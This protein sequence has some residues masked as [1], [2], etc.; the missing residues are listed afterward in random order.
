MSDEAQGS[1]AVPRST[2]ILPVS[3]TG[4]PP[5]V[6][7]PGQQGRD[8]PATHGQDARDT[9]GRDARAT[10]ERGRDARD[11]K[12]RQG[13]WLLRPLLFWV[14]VLGGALSLQLVRKGV[15]PIFD[16]TGVIGYMGQLAHAEGYR[17]PSDFFR[18]HWR[19]I[20]YEPE[21][22]TDPVPRPLQSLYRPLAVCTVAYKTLACYVLGDHPW[23]P[24]LV[25]I[26]LSAL[27]AGVL[28][29]L[30]LRLTGNLLVAFGGAFL[31]L[32]SVPSIAGTFVSA[33]GEQPLVVLLMGLSLY[34]YV[35]FQQ[36]GRWGWAIPIFILSF[37]GPIYREYSGIAAFVIVAVELVTRRRWWFIAAM[38]PL[39]FHSIYTSFFINLLAYQHVVLLSIMAKTRISDAVGQRQFHPEA[40]NH[41]LFL[42]APVLSLLAIAGLWARVRRAIPASRPE[43]QALLAGLALVLAI[44]WLA[45]FVAPG[46]SVGLLT[47]ERVK[48]LPLALAVV[49]AAS[50]WPVSR[51]LAIWTAFTFLPYVSAFNVEIH[52][53]YAVAPLAM[54]LMVNVAALLDGLRDPA[55]GATDTAP[56]AV[57]VPPGDEHRHAEQQRV[58]GTPQIEPGSLSRLGAWLRP[59]AYVTAF[60]LML[61]GLVDQGFNLGA[62]GTVFRGT[63]RAARQLGEG[64][65]QV[66]RR[67][68]VL[69][70]HTLLAD[71]VRYYFRQDL[72]LMLQ[73]RCFTFVK[74]VGRDHP[75]CLVEWERFESTVRQAVQQSP[76]LLLD[77][78]LGAPT[79]LAQHKQRLIEQGWL[80]HHVWRVVFDRRYSYADPL[81]YFVPLSYTSF[82]GSPDLGDYVRMERSWMSRRVLAAHGLYQVEP[83]LPPA[84]APAAEKP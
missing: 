12:R 31:G 58:R 83:P 17:S 53:L 36:G 42:V 57:S 44:L 19:D 28:Y 7:D 9:H 65:S 80:V 39:L 15:R 52:Q 55:S 37:L 11:T 72:G 23:L 63:N 62:V 75:D 48:W 69:I 50:A 3:P 78:D 70:S 51:L 49:M 34:C 66:S 81:K 41:L 1:T 54:C 46:E 79:M 76:V 4:V 33:S 82:P 16:E 35:R 73:R 61:V 84:S 29:R 25:N 2:G 6:P 45:L 13:P 77:V 43:W 32:F 26:A 10:A 30:G 22:L 21:K 40:Y 5:V 64:I 71:D 14:L 24:P 67:P 8:A 56:F 27:A 47:Y 60:L 20:W 18:L 38:L 74:A 59:F 68:A